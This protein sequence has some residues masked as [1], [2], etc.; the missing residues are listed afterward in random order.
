MKI[1]RIVLSVWL[2]CTAILSVLGQ[3]GSLWWGF[4]TLSLFHDRLALTAVLLLAAWLFMRSW[5]WASLAALTLGFNAWLLVPYAPLPSSLQTLAA[6]TSDLKVMSYNVYYENPD[7]ASILEEVAKYKPDIVFLMEYSSAVQAE[8]EDKF[9][10]YPYKL[11]EPSRRT[12]GLALFSKLPFE[13]SEVHRFAE[14]RIPIFEVEFELNGQLVSFVGGHPWPPIGRWGQF[15]QNQMLDLIKVA[16]AAQHPL[17]VAG[18]FNASQWS[19]LAKKLSQEA[20]VKDARQG[21][22]LRHTFRIAP[23]VSIPLDHV[24]T[25]DNWHVSDYQ[26]GDKR[27]SDHNSIVV[28]LKLE[29]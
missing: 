28:T 1:I 2:V 16:A 13:Q 7:P 29:E 9:S 21:F 10:D 14:T 22:G 4:D 17:I 6:E 12:M 3:L 26:T 8:I 5:R 24:F 18:D 19:F 11:I 20:S 23:L 25:S 27:G 15:H